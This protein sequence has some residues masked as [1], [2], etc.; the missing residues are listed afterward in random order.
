MCP[1]EALELRGLG[2]N[3]TGTP[4]LIVWPAQDPSETPF[5]QL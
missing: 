2:L 3:R 5:P 4:P 1:A